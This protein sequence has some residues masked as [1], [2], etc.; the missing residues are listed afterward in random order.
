MLST[1]RY[2]RSTLPIHPIPVLN[3]ISPFLHSFVLACFL[4]IVPPPKKKGPAVEMTV[5]RKPGVSSRIGRND[6]SITSQ[7]HLLD[8]S[9]HVQFISLSIG[10]IIVS[11]PLSLISNMYPE[12]VS[13]RTCPKL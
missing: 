10:A 2:L 5:R 12:R 13:T 4:A 1:K 11:G 3:E 9:C 7:L 8:R 6:R